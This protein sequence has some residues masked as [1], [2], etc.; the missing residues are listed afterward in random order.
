VE[1]VTR[2]QRRYLAK[3]V[4]FFALLAVGMNWCV[5]KEIAWEKRQGIYQNKWVD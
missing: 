1:A 2:R 4:L 5:G 3:W